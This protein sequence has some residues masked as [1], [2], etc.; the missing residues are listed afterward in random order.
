MAPLTPIERQAHAVKEKIIP[1]VR[2]VGEILGKE[3]PTTSSAL[4]GLADTDW[5]RDYY[6]ETK[7]DSSRKKLACLSAEKLQPPAWE[8]KKGQEKLPQDRGTFRSTEA[9]TERGDL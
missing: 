1:A 2:D 7:W 3:I 9:A 4:A 5:L 6:D 8:A